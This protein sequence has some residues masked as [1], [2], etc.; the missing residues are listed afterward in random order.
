MPLTCKNDERRDCQPPGLE[1]CVSE[2]KSVKS[3][4]RLKIFCFNADDDVE[5]CG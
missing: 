4:F 3:F 5:K 1:D 2:H